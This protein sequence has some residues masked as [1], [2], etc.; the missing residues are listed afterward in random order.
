M[1][2][3]YMSFFAKR[4]LTLSFA[5]VFLS[6]TLSFAFQHP[7]S[8]KQLPSELLQKK[9][10]GE[11]L[12]SEGDWEACINTYLSIKQECD[13]QGISDLGINLYEDIFT[14]IVIR[15]D[16]EIEDKLVL[17]Q[18]YKNQEK[19]AKFTGLYT[20]ALSHLYAF[21]GEIDS[22]EHYYDIACKKHQQLECDKLEGGLNINLAYELYMLDELQLAKKYLERA[23]GILEKKLLPSGLDLPNI[24]NTQT[25]VYAGLGEYEKALKSSLIS[26]E[27]LK[28]DAQAHPLDLAYEYNN[29]ASV[30]GSLQDLNNTLNYYQKAVDLMEGLGEEFKP[31]LASI[32]YNMGATYFEQ[33]NRIAAKNAFLKSLSYLDQA[34]E[35]NSDV[36]SDY[37]NNCHQLVLCYQ[38]NNQID[39]VLHYLQIAEKINQTYPYRITTTYRL[40]GQFYSDQKEY[41]KAQQYVQKSLDRGLEVY[42]SK[43]EFAYNAYQLMNE[44]ALKQKKYTKALFYCQKA[45]EAISIDFSDEQGYSN[46]KLENTSHKQLLIKTLKDKANILKTLYHLPNSS[47]QPADIYASAKLATQALEQ[48]NKS[49]K[50]VES[51]RF[52]LNTTAIPLF[53]NAIEVA[54]DIYNTTGD[55][56]YLNEAFTLSERSKSMLMTDA[57]Q[58]AN[59][60]SFGEVPEKLIQQAQDLQKS[61]ADAEKR[62]FD[63]RIEGNTELEKIQD[64]LIFKN[65]HA[66]DL[67]IHTFENKYP[68]YFELKYSTSSATISQIQEVLDAQTAFIEYFEG[69]HT[70]YAFTITHT[71]THVNIIPKEA[72]YQ[73]RIYNFQRAL[74]DLNS[75]LRKPAIAYN[76]FVED[77]YFFYQKLLKDNIKDQPKR[78]IIVP[79]GQLGYV[80][81][82]ALL[83]APVRLLEQQAKTADYT[84]LP[85]LVKDYT[86]SYNYSGTLL[87][88]QQK[89]QH[90]IINNKILALAPS[91]TSSATP[92]WRGQREVKLRTHLDDLPGA[93]DEV[94]KLQ[95][96]FGGSFF[97]GTKAT[98]TV[99]KEN[100][101]QFGILHLAMH[102]LVNKKNPEFSGLALTEDM[103]KDQDNFLYAYEIKQLNLKTS[104]VVLSACETGIGKYQHGEGVVSIGRSFMYAGTPALLMTL[105]RLNDDSG[106]LIIEKF[107]QNLDQGMEKDEAIRQAKLAYINQADPTAAHPF[108]WAAFIQVGDYAAIDIAAPTHWSYYLLWG[109]GALF[110]II[111]IIF[112]LKNRETNTHL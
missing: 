8:P 69:K 80:P 68:K 106:A 33:K 49:M 84:Q 6:Y 82:E 59:A 2:P 58:E 36:L 101:N 86:I 20:G 38:Q 87:L 12:M 74:I 35:K 107:Y 100:A 5:L 10:K 62:R 109:F 29:L 57:M 70:I 81:F 89:Q 72:D 65:K 64:S 95:N 15:D 41:E 91:Y 76:I 48:M 92:E 44:I 56:K 22:M 32:I 75:A 16:I 37:I 96:Q 45:I 4:N 54:L 51:K 21:Y 67:L 7:N 90:N 97:I 24:Y 105:W 94:R 77:A 93:E 52:W 9:K 3:L 88:S 63:A 71:G 40:Y 11:R 13:N 42:G 102:G 46:P 103:S 73:K 111:L 43:G 53:E 85:Y 60:S 14:V 47:I 23:E 39:S 28:K 79:D 19:H 66:L 55:E 108:L 31:E 104:L 27:H 83:T 78:L 25:M 34:Q 98:E 61:L 110:L 1:K 50:N 99:F 112:L 30:Y 18:N 26:I 17:I